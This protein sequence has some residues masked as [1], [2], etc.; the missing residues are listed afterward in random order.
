VLCAVGYADA[1][2]E[3]GSIDIWLASSAGKILVCSRAE[4][5]QFDEDAAARIL[6]EDDIWI[7]VDLHDGEKEGF[8]YGCDLTYNYVR[9]NARYRT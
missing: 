4:A 7:I 2:F 1:D 9:I 5:V 8:A 3:C 6:A